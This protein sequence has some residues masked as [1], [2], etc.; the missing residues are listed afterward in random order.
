MREPEEEEEAYRR[1]AGDLSFDQF[2][3]IEDRPDLYKRV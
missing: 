2:F 1:P 3:E